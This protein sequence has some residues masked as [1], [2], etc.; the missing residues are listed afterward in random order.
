MIL[1]G[2]SKDMFAQS[3]WH[4]GPAQEHCG[5][6]GGGGGVWKGIRWVARICKEGEGS[7]GVVRI[8][9]AGGCGWGVQWGAR[10]GGGG[11][12]LRNKVQRA[13]LSG[14]S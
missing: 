6:G 11:A 13:F 14:V 3:C 4:E 9:K 1:P 7:G 12:L 8:C 2:E 10:A 5:G